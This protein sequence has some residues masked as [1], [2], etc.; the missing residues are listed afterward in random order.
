MD[1]NPPNS[2]RTRRLKT[3]AAV[4]ALFVI[5]TMLFL[6]F[7]SSSLS[8]PRHAGPTADVTLAREQQQVRW[9]GAPSLALA[10]DT[11]SPLS[12]DE[13][14]RHVGQ[15]ISSSQ[16]SL[17][18]QQASALTGTLAAQ[19]IARARP[20]GAD[21]VGKMN[22]TC[23]RWVRPGDTKQWA[24]IAV[25]AQESLGMTLTE[26]TEEAILLAVADYCLR[27]QS[28][29]FRSLGLGEKGIAVQVMRVRSEPELHARLASVAP[30]EAA[31]WYGATH[32]AFMLRMPRRD[33]SEVLR[34]EGAATCA[35]VLAVVEAGEDRRYTWQS[36]WFWD[37]LNGCWACHSMARSG[38]TH[39]YWMFY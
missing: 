17:S 7:R 2:N 25:F 11:G 14:Q 13:L 32:A 35:H 37:E 39:G 1:V 10:D 6:V 12:L 27:Q 15:A 3:V 21:Y 20:S 33:L 30:E 26:G 4:L 24:S 28:G 31:Y 38:G 16:G 23:A 29:Y 36:L 22:T 34:T 8:G 9:K 18:P 19:V 5:A